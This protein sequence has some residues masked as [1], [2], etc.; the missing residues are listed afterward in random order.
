MGVFWKN[1]RNGAGLAVAVVAAMAGYSLYK[2]KP[3]PDHN[4]HVVAMYRI[5]PYRTNRIARAA[6]DRCLRQLLPKERRLQAE[7]SP[8]LVDAYTNGLEHYASWRESRLPTAF[9]QEADSIRERDQQVYNESFSGMT[10]VQRAT[11]DALRA[12]VRDGVDPYDCVMG[13][14]AD[15]RY[16]VYFSDN[17]T[18][19]RGTAGTGS[20]P[21]ALSALA[22]AN[23]RN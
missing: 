4:A 23:V 9:K 17:E 18:G 5:D 13:R 2:A 10:P 14:V 15:A 1:A 6:T 16:T 3:G 11:A 20:S 22:D 19:F 21:A 12:K 8:L 7:I